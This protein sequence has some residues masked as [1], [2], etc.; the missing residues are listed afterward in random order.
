[1]NNGS[2]LILRACFLNLFLQKL[3][4]LFHPRRD[5]HLHLFIF[6]LMI[7]MV[8]AMAVIMMTYRCGGAGAEDLPGRISWL[9]LFVEG[10]ACASPS[11]GVADKN[12]V[13]HE[14][15]NVTKSGVLGTFGEL[16]IF[17][18]RKFSLE[19]IEQTIYHE[20][21]ALVSNDNHPFIQLGNAMLSPISA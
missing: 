17:W 21:L 12:A 18:C 20:T 2:W 1:L 3:P 16:G 10:I 14:K 7:V 9:Q 15:Q 5:R 8:I 4:V 11:F 19:A 13:S 6:M